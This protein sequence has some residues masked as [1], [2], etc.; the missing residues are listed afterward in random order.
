MRVVNRYVI[1]ERMSLHAGARILSTE[2]GMINVLEDPSAPVVE[3]KFKIFIS[4]EE[5]N[6]QDLK[7][8]YV[9]SWGDKH[10]IRLVD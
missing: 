3:Q 7:G 5:F 8:D 2:G 6:E 10:V 9:G 1:S 4:G